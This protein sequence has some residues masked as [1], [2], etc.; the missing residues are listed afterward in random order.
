MHTGTTG[1]RVRPL[2]PIIAM[3]PANGRPRT[4]WSPNFRAWHLT[5]CALTLFVC[6][7]TACEDPP[8]PSDGVRAVWT[9]HEKGAAA[10][11]YVDDELSVF[12]TFDEARVVALDTR[13]GDVAW[14]RRL[15]LPS[16][17]PF[18]GLPNANIVAF[19]D[20]VIVPAWDVYAL[21][22]RSGAVRWRFQSIDDF[23]GAG[24]VALSAG[25]VYGTGRLLYALDARTGALLWQT[26]LGEQPFYPVV[27][28]GV[29]YVAT[30]RETPPG[31]GVLGAG[32]ALAVD[33][34]TGAIIWKYPIS[35][36][37]PSQQGGSVGP[38]FVGEEL[39]LVAGINGR[40]YALERQTGTLRWESAG[41]GR[42]SAGVVVLDGTV[43]VASSVGS[44]EGFDLATGTRRWQSPPASSVQATITL[45]GNSV[46][47]AV[48]TLTAY[49]TDGRTLWQHGGAGFGGP[50][51]TTPATYHGGVVYVGSTTGFHAIR[52]PTQ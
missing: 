9:H 8:A 21:D 25:R 6:S 13:T 3:G 42:Y 24:E 31:S 14:T 43:I 32:H 5:G 12:T 22:R 27:A 10:Q 51:Y 49:D 37:S 11:P 45:G 46:L 30:R 39:V 50:V 48:G 15:S 29:V 34:L 52:P 18:Q 41:S 7:A 35:D 4:A 28:G 36:V 44:V 20:L 26:D 1:D 38:L 16:G 19:E 2:V 23:P 33:A 17:I 40:V 47:V